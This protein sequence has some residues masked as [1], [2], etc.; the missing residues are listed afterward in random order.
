[1]S[2]SGKQTKYVATAQGAIRSPDGADQ[3]SR[4]DY[5]PE[6]FGYLQVEGF[7]D[8]VLGGASAPADY[9]GPYGGLL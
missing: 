2:A 8:V 4:G 7:E 6:P 3:R 5:K 9:A 1:M